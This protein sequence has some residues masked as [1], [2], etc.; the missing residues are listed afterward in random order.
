MPGSEVPVIRQPFRPGD[1]LP[2]WVGS[3]VVD[4]HFLFDLSDDPD[5]TE[6]LAGTGAAEEA[7]MLD[8]LRLALKRVEAPEEQLQ[9]LGIA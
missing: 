4:A 3:N 2:F 7:E 9:R 8:V 6:N 5:E 1:R